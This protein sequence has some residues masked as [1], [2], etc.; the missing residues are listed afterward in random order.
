MAKWFHMFHRW[1]E[2]PGITVSRSATLPEGDF[3]ITEYRWD[4]VSLWFV[5]A[6]RFTARER[7]WI[8]CYHTGKRAT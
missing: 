1:G 8:Y 6:D 7:H 3:Q 4:W 2:C 5:D